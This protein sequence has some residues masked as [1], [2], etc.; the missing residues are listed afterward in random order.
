[1][2]RASSIIR[3]GTFWVEMPASLERTGLGVK[4]RL[5]SESSWKKRPRIKVVI[6]FFRAASA[7]VRS[8]P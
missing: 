5:L 3:E 4:W 6:S 8:F 2:G 7:P 1:M